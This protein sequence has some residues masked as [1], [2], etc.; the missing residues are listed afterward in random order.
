[1]TLQQAMAAAAEIFGKRLGNF[2]TGADLWNAMNKALAQV[3]PSGTTLVSCCYTIDNVKFCLDNVTAA[4]CSTLGGVS[5]S[6]TC[7]QRT[8]CGS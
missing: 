2:T 8:D 5:S 1:M 6:Q 3:P 7:A 4:E